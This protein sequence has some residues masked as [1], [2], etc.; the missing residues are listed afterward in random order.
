MK[1][2]R[3]IIEEPQQ[4]GEPCPPDLEEYGAP[5][6]EPPFDCDYKYN[7]V[8]TC[9]PKTGLQ[10]THL[11]IESEP[12]NNGKVCPTED[13]KYEKCD[14][15]CVWTYA[16]EGTCDPKTGLQTTT[17]QVSQVAWNNGKVCP[18][19]D[20]KY[21]K[22][23]VD[24]VSSYEAGN[25]N[26]DKATGLRKLDLVIKT[27]SKNKGS[28]CPSDLFKTVPCQVDCESKLTKSGACYKNGG[29]YS[30]T[31]LQKYS[32][33]IKVQPKNGGTACPVDPQIKSCIDCVWQYSTAWS[34][35]KNGKKSRQVEILN[36][37]TDGGEK[38]PCDSENK[39]Y[40]KC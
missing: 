2:T 27:E 18:T 37:P 29:S 1:R 36:T 38:C 23:D 19:E 33:D 28:A 39:I 26:C 22:C 24:C 12:K 32:V 14:V 5:C 40:A 10:Q 11:E 16:D 3:R 31:Y 7:P 17:L 34:S 6:G 20:P 30:T 35:C 4:G 9:D 13:P 21:E 8:G 25:N 15:D